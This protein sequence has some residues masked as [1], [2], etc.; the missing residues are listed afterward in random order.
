MNFNLITITD[1]NGS[2]VYENSISNSEN[3][4]MLNMDLTKFANGVYY[5]LLKNN[6]F[7]ISKSIIKQ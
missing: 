5:L 6:S 7:T 3:N 4:I 2:V 1:I